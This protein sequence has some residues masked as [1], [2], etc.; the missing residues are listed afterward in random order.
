MSYILFTGLTTGV[1]YQAFKDWKNYSEAYADCQGRNFKG[2]AKIGT[3]N[4]LNQARNSSGYDYH[5]K[6]WTALQV[7]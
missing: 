7:L 5:R 6:H 3:S 4:Q 2:L 1:Q